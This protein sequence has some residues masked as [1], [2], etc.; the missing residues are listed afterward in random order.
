MHIITILPTE[1]SCNCGYHKDTTTVEE[2]RVFAYD[3]AS[4][5]APAMITTHVKENNDSL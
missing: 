3:H 2:A 1:V 5:S 4:V